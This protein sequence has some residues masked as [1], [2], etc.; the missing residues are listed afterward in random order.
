[1]VGDKSKQQQAGTDQPSSNDS[2]CTPGAIQI[3]FEANPS[4][5]TILPFA[6]PVIP[7]ADPEG[8]NRS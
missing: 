5:I 2:D 4:P 8:K 3:R 7:Q 6:D 1:L